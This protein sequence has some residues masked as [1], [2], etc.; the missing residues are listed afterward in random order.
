[1]IT[2][3]P[4]ETQKRLERVSN[5]IIGFETPYG[6]ELLVTVHW[7]GTKGTTLAT[8]PKFV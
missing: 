6:M 3:P 4:S 1:M 8:T 5:L 7:V 2:C